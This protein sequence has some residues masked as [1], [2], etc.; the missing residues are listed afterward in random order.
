MHQNVRAMSVAHCVG[1]G[2]LCAR[3]KKITEHM[4]LVV[5]VVFLYIGM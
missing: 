4:Y 1:A 5:F 2:A 3:T